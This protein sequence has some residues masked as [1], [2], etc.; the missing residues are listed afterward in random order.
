M[1]AIEPKSL[2]IKPLTMNTIEKGI[3]KALDP[4]KMTEKV[5]PGRIDGVWHQVRN[6]YTWARFVESMEYFGIVGVP[7]ARSRFSR[8]LKSQIRGGGEATYFTI[9]TYA[10]NALQVAYQEIMLNEYAEAA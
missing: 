9:S 8:F 10:L 5:E 2:L 4:L 7:T 3:L 6:W 1:E